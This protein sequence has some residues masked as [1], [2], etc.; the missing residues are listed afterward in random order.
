MASD[1]RIRGGKLAAH[2]DHA[3]DVLGKG[4]GD[5]QLLSGAPDLLLLLR[6]RPEGLWP[7][8][9]PLGPGDAVL[10]GNLGELPPSDLLNLLHMSKRTGVLLARDGNAERG[11]ALISGNVAW[12]CS[13][14][15][16]E[17]LGE[18]LA[19]SGAV[20]RKRVEEA[21]RE[22]ARLRSRPDEGQLHLGQILEK[23]EQLP[24]EAMAEA[25][26]HQIVEIFL[27]L[28]L[29]RSGTFVFQGGCDEAK[30]PLRLNLDTQGLL[31]DGLRRLD[32]MADLRER[33]PSLAVRLVPR[34]KALPAEG[35]AAASEQA[36]L[37]F[38]RLDGKR[39]LGEAALEAG[40]SEYEA[41]KAA[42]A[43]LAGGWAA[44]S[45]GPAK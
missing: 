19:R 24:P 40:L 34:K 9:H 29:L 3:R 11:L 44:L 45:G 25:L 13:N 18:M 12:A 8:L 22:Q 43:L 36:R 32:E 5:F 21:L 7:A 37:L 4:D 27:G 1:L 23:R 35:N 14:C 17:R 38:A 15:P 20:P 2:S 39:A 30:L 42:A 33:I 28:L 6:E 10:A 26:R 16:G 31:L 41:T